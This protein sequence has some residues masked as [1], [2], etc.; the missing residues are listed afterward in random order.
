MGLDEWAS[1][2]HQIYLLF[3]Y[4]LMGLWLGSKR[5]VRARRCHGSGH[6]GHGDDGHGWRRIASRGPPALDVRPAAFRPSSAFRP[7]LRVPSPSSV[8]H[9]P[10][11]IL[12]APLRSA[13]PPARSVPL[14]QVPTPPP[15]SAPTS[16]FRP[17][18]LHMYTRDLAAIVRSVSLGECGGGVGGGG[19]GGGVVRLRELA[20]AAFPTK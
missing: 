8:F 7:P 4:Y 9:P 13:P 12:P 16:A 17:P 20:E 2:R 14:L 10:L 19:W 5:A 15:H 18:P 6:S 11:R 1:A 3:L